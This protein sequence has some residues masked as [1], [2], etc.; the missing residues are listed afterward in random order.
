MKAVTCPQC[1]GLIDKVYDFQDIVR[2]KYCG[3]NV[4]M[5]TAKPAEYVPE[6]PVLSGF[7][8][9]SAA[10]KI[11]AVVTV[12]AIGFAALLL[13][14]IYAN[15]PHSGGQPTPRPSPYKPIIM[16]HMQ[17]VPQKT[18]TAILE[19][20]GKGT[21][22]GLFQDASAA[23]VG[24]DGSIYVADG[25]LRVQRFDGAGKFLNVWNVKGDPKKESITKIA[26]AASG[27]VYVLIGGQIVIFDGQ[28][29]E[30]KR[31]LS[32][33]RRESIDDFALRDDGGLMYVAENGSNEDIVQT[34][35]KAIVN[36][37]SGIL[38]KAADADLSTEGIKIAVD[39]KGDF[40]AVFALGG[41]SGLH[42]YNE[43]DLMTFHFSPQGKFL[44]KFAADLMPSALA[45]DNQGRVYVLNNKGQSEIAV[46]TGAGSLV[47]RISAEAFAAGSLAID[48]QNFIYVIDSEKVRKLRPVD[49]DD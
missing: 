20:G 23:A 5:E 43:E 29:G 14:V 46:Y 44:N 8:A 18:T 38:T 16:P 7:P 37:F 47:T 35:D 39:G 13:S 6:P 2:C 26:A 42:S 9:P 40:Y 21:G 28:T 12:F 3:A 11:I 49:S 17:D 31:V 41:I 36:R 34:K 25:T 22:P 1:G 24:P 27:E 19:F 4:L 15:R 33:S 30:Q 48:K 32:D 10:P 45:T